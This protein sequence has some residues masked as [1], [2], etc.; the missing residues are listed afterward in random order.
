LNRDHQITAVFAGE[1]FASHRRAC[2]FV[3]DSAR[4][5]V[6]QPFD[7][8]IT[9]NSGY[10]LDLNLYQTVKGISAAAQVVKQGGVIVCASECSD[11]IPNHGSY[12]RV[13]AGAQTPADL[14]DAIKSPGYSQADQWQAQVQ[15]QVQMKS[16]V[17]VR[18]DC[19]TDEQLRSCH[20]EPCPNIEGLVAAELQ[21][22]GASASICVLPLGPL[23]MPYVE[24][25]RV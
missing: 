22:R 2:A 3:K 14:L 25:E 20:L 5:G 8:V 4:Q 12:A 23:T 18:S 10:P 24:N 7:I 16:R 13:L 1:V 17:A 9:T 6:L 21:G 15:A 11:G 19:L